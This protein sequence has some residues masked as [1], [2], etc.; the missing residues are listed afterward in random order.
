[1]R[2]LNEAWRVLSDS[3][4]R[5]AYDRALREGTTYQP[6]APPPTLRAVPQ[7]NLA[8]F[9]ARRATGGTCLV[10][11]MVALVLIFALSVLGWGLDTHLNFGAIINRAAG[12]VNALLPIRAPESTKVAQ[13]QPTPTPDPRCR[14]GCETPPPGCVV[15][16]DIESNGSR[17][18]YLPN[19]EGYAG[20]RVNTETGDRWFCALN[21]AQA[22]GWTRKAPTATPTIALPPEA[23]TTAVA[24]RSFVVCAENVALH[25][26]PGDDFPVAQNAANGAP[27][28]ISGVNGEWSVV[29]HENSTL[30]VRTNLLCA[31]TRAAGLAPPTAA[32]APVS[33]TPAQPSTASTNAATGPF[34]YPAPQLLVPTFGEKYWCKRELILQWSLSAPPLA[35]EEYFLIESKLVEHSTWIALSDWTK[36]TTIVL[37]PSRDRG[38]CDAVW[39][40]NTGVY[41]W[42]VSVVTGNKE[43]PTY[44]SPFSEPSRINYGK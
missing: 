32:G 7:A 11:L 30:Y 28:V 33:A 27:L 10:T 4:Q 1:M 17:F 31:P 3:A 8:D 41:E 34:K 15:K 6:P 12:E 18:F 39:W 44:L 21:D 9:G 25:Q 42:R 13:E 26:G 37:S 35:P 22:A 2:D 14:D 20:V 36:E 19:D 29:N 38:E 43:M 16:G 24:R 40:G 5:A 23:F